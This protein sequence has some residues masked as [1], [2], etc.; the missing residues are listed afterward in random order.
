M[1]VKGLTKCASGNL[2]PSHFTRSTCGI[3]NSESRMHLPGP[4]PYAFQIFRL[5]SLHSILEIKL[6]SAIFTFK[7]GFWI[8]NELHNIT[9]TPGTP[10]DDWIA[11]TISL[12]VSMLDP[13][14]RWTL[15]CILSNAAFL[16]PRPLTTLWV[17]EV[18]AFYGNPMK[19]T[20][21]SG[22]H[23]SSPTVVAFSIVLPIKDG[24]Q[25]SQVWLQLS[26]DI[27]HNWKHRVAVLVAGLENVYKCHHL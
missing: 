25:L 1:G 24:F 23:Y 21:K 12:E 18:Q 13:W 8:C 14:L 26:N 16:S 11:S 2:S 20:C 17:R 15:M 6:T 3:L 9:W 4:M 19:A 5:L 27:L 10:P 7:E 22:S